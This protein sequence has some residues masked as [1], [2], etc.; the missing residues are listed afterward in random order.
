MG[1]VTL[2]LNSTLYRYNFASNTS[3]DHAKHGKAS[4]N[5]SLD[6]CK[7]NIFTANLKASN[8]YEAPD[9]VLW[10]K[11]F[12]TT[13]NKYKV[14]GMADN[15]TEESDFDW[16]N[17][18][19][20]NRT[21]YNDSYSVLLAS[22]NPYYYT[23]DTCDIYYARLYTIPSRE[24]IWNFPLLKED[25]AIVSYNNSKLSEYNCISWTARTSEYWL[26]PHRDI[27]NQNIR[28]FDMLYYN[29]PVQIQDGSMF[30]RDTYLPKYTR[31]GATAENSVIDLWGI[32]DVNGNITYTHASIRN[33]Y[34]DN[35]P[36]GYDWESKLGEDVRIFHPRY[37]LEGRLYGNVVAHYRLVDENNNNNVRTIQQQ[38][39][40][41]DIIVETI[42]LTESDLAI[43]NNVIANIPL[44][45]ETNF[46]TLYNN[47]KQ[48]VEQNKHKADM[49]AHKECP[50]YTALLTC[51]QSSENGEYLAYKKFAEDDFF[52]MLLIQDFAYSSDDTKNIWDTAFDN[53]NLGNIRRSQKSKV[54]L[55]IQNMIEEQTNI[56]NYGA[57][58]S[59]SNTDNF[60]VTS[61]SNTIKINIE[62]EETSTYMIEVI[63]LSNNY[64]QTVVP[65]IRVQAGEYEH[66]V[67]VPNGIYVVAYYLNGNINSKKIQVK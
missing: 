50:Q 61:S 46:N 49:W 40:E 18:A 7:Y 17:N 21:F 43:V 51:I 27:G 24:Q 60:N 41:E 57:G 11:K 58:R 26:W 13:T 52:A 63:D 6:T 31:D 55:F 48:Y 67:N 59:F 5:M 9:P 20:F 53:S 25:D 32:E 29:L 3:F 4:T 44:T 28:W 64:V 39:A 12:D 35:I 22:N 65:E 47:W 33:H 56:F 45:Q 1:G 10:L 15:Y 62:I 8:E 34:E 66:T 37:A 54:N 38:V 42:T 30:Q 14:V 23:S 16:G 36:H 2:R 19:R